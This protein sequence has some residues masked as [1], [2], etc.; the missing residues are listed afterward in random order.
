MPRSPVKLV[1]FDVGGVLLRVCTSFEEGVN[2]AGLPVRLDSAEMVRGFDAV[3]DAREEYRT[4]KID[5]RELARRVSTAFGGAYSLEEV[6]AVMHS[7]VRETYPQTMPMLAALKDNG[8]CEIAIFSNTCLDHWRQITA[9]PWMKY[10]DHAF[11]SHELGTAK[12]SPEAFAAI[13]K[14]TRVPPE[15]ILFF[16]DTRENIAASVH[17]RWNSVWIDSAG[18]IN[19][20]M[21]AALL[22]WVGTLWGNS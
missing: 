8:A 19:S 22:K 3:R 6:C 18:D 15:Q 20:Q 14:I 4:G 2:A 9:R 21:R 17:R 12:P 5:T 16:D 11:A 7:W 13:E 10:V 1:C